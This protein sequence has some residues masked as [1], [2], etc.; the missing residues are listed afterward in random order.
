MA[1]RTEPG[2]ESAI[3]V[4]VDPGELILWTGRPDTR[5]MIGRER[6]R[7]RVRIVL[8][9]AALAGI[10]W[11]ASRMAP[12]GTLAFPQLLPLL[13]S[14]VLVF[15]VLVLIG[16]HIL[17]L[18]MLRRFQR[19]VSS[20]A[21]AITDRRLLV[22]EGDRI[23]DAYAPEQLSQ[24]HV[25]RRSRGFGDVIFGRRTAMHTGGRRLDRVQRERERVGFKALADPDAV[26]ARIEEWLAGHQRHAESESAAFIHDLRKAPDG[27]DADRHAVR[28][29]GAVRPIFHPAL[30]LRVEFPSS[31]RVRV[32]AKKKPHGRVFL[33]RERWQEPADP[34]DWN[35][36]LGE[37][38]L[39]CAVEVEVFETEPTVTFEDLS[40]SRLAAMG[41]SVTD[42]QPAVEINAL[43]GFSVTRRRDVQV[44][45]VGVATLAATVIRE[46]LIVLQDSR[47]QVCVRA[48]WPEDSEDLAHAVDAVVRSI[49]L[50]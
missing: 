36:V 8:V 50:D 26:Q 40:T 23:V 12:A 24:V 19:Y 11:L 44:S 29:D 43:S 32:R 28:P 49:R 6:V 13:E 15:A 45:E 20:L 10:A 17:S 38:P 27:D 48:T 46:R 41:G 31:W 47:R 18:F 33:D 7:W 9:P 1:L 34:G 37:G 25:R 42:A 16:L 30:G 14:R 4:L 5:I 21:Y 2:V 35:L 22:A 3:S 39:R